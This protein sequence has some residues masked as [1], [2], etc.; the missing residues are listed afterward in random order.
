MTQTYNITAPNGQKYKVTGDTPE[1]AVAALK[2]MLA[3]SGDQGNVSDLLPPP[4]T[5]AEI[6]RGARD[7]EKPRDTFT[8]TA[9]AMMEG[10]LSAA[11]TFGSALASG[12]E[13]SPTLKAIAGDPFLGKLPG[14]VQAGLGFAGD[15]G[16]GALSLIGAGLSGAAGLASE[17]VPGQS[18][19]DEEKLAQGLVDMSMFAV[20][21]LSGASSIA[22]RTGKVATAL[23]ETQMA[24]D[25]AAA[26]KAGIPVYRTDV[27]PPKTFV[28]KTFR[29]MG[30]TIP[31]AGTGGLRAKQAQSRVEAA[32]NL[33]REYG[34]DLPDSVVSEVTSDLLVKRAADVARYS[35]QKAE[36]IQGLDGQPVPTPKTI[37]AI[38]A[39]IAALK[40]QNLPELA[41]VISRL[42]GWKNG[43]SGQ[44][45]A[46]LE[47]NRKIIGEAFKAPELASVRKVGE[48]ALSA[49]YGP[50]RED[51][52][53]FIK[54]NGKSGDFMKWASANVRLHE[55]IGDLKIHAF[56]SI[57]EKGEATPELVR[58]M[59]FSQKPS[60]VAML[61]RNLTPDGQARARTAIIQEVFAKAGGEIEKISPER[62]ANTIARMG[63]Q[64]RGFFRGEQLE[65]VTG[66][67]RA[68]NLTRHAA[69]AKTFAPTG[70]QNF[71]PVLGLGLGSAL[72][73]AKSVGVGGSIGLAARIYEST[74]VQRALRSLAKAASD[75]AQ[76]VALR[77]LSEA[78]QRAGIKAG[79]VGAAVNNPESP[80]MKA[81]RA[82][83]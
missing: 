28:G 6:F 64:I 79:D 66:L 32:Q 74:G 75:S 48:K 20:P 4:P 24:K 70:M 49:I 7:R 63:P 59:L 34:A 81:G 19:R 47:E 9:G 52:G 72:G 61:Y 82:A 12:G 29:K 53:G 78:F 1:G 31:L 37:E 46:T 23:P 27:V 17:L 38:D 2:K 43:L 33:I 13:G 69:E 8:D 67:V 36:V 35:K 68:I 15:L 73:F 10:P 54:A 58:S 44:T 45:L 80:V 77:S 39:Q 42:E 76:E 55:G 21:E 56:K 25:V 3:Q 30:E 41:P 11:G 60:D 71:G 26:K 62:V 18:P 22:A 50:L 14:P 51:M 5:E 40:Q 83:Q 16:G 57:L 65:A